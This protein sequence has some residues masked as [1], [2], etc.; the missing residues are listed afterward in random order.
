MYIATLQLQRALVFSF[1]IGSMCGVGVGGR[2]GD[3]IEVGGICGVEMPGDN[4]C[5]S[6]CPGPL[7]LVISAG[8]RHGELEDVGFLGDI[9]RRHLKVGFG[10]EVD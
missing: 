10:V 5:F 4:F 1:S 7:V 2:L 8:N 6:L 9:W 3:I